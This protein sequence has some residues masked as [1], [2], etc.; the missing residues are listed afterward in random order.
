MPT[1]LEYDRVAVD[2]CWDHID[3]V[4]A[5]RY[6]ENHRNDTAW[7]L[8]EGIEIDRIIEDY[9]GLLTFVRGK[10]RSK[11]HV[12][13]SFDEWNVWYKAMG[14][15]HQRGGWGEAPPR[16]E[17]VYNFE[18]ALVA[19][20]YLMAF[21]RRADVVKVACLAQIVNVIAP[22]LTRPDG[23]LIQSIYH[24]IAQ[25]ARLAHGQ[26]LVTLVDSTKY[27][28]GERGDVAALDAAASYDP[29]TGHLAAFL[30][31]RD[32]ARALTATVRLADVAVDSV[33]ATLLGGVDVKA[34]NTWETPNAVSPKAAE[35][36]Q[37]EPGTLRVTIPGPG[38][39]SLSVKTSRR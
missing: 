8:A 32:P 16:L 11:K 33:S 21:I 2:A 6:S 27:R 25:I 29:A 20:Q 22:I 15:K 31:N 36:E 1:Y 35:V 39:M 9:A 7:F 12:H 10:R 34:A 38:M 26:S 13:L 30:V 37:P 5:H 24:P 19:A 17:E 3:Y 18:D 23:V 28:A 14:D 4:S